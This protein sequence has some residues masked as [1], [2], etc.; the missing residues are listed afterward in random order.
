MGNDAP[1]KER[2]TCKDDEK[3]SSTW[4]GIGFLVFLVFYFVFLGLYPQHRK[5][6]RGPQKGSN[7]SCSCRPTPQPQQHRIRA[8]SATYTTAPSYA[9]SLTQKVRPGI[10]SPSS[11]TL[12]QVLSATTRFS[13]LLAVGPGQVTEPAQGPCF[14]ICETGQSQYPS[15]CMV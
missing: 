15:Q 4:K 6:T 1:F 5:V 2:K 11:G 7:Q 3:C 8:A 9:E 12:C 14:P 13:H 10:E